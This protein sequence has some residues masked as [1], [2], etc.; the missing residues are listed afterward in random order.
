MFDV[1]LLV[2]CMWRV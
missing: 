1:V 2:W